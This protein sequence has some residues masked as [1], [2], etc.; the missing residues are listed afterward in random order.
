MKL[1]EIRKTVFEKLKTDKTNQSPR[2]DGDLIVMHNLSLTKADLI[3]KDFEVSYDKVKK[4]LSDT[5]KRLKK[6]PVAYILGK[7]EFMS[8][9]FFVNE[10][11]LIPRPDTEILVEHILDEYKNKAE[12][13][14]LVDIG[15]GSGCIAISLLKNQKNFTA[16]MLDISSGALSVA[17]KNAEKHG[18]IDRATFLEHNI[19]N[20]FL[21]QIQNV[22][23]IVSNPPYIPE[24]DINSL[25]PDVKDYEPLS[26]LSGGE[27]GLMF[28]ESIIK[29]ASLNMGGM[30]AF[31]VGINQSQ[32][33]AFLMRQNGFSDILTI[34]DYGGIDRVVSGRKL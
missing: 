25:M 8:L 3:T 20:G 33:V 24:K 11:T 15:T 14:H 10:H 17:K 28:Y 9:D 13:I 31:E 30:L 32:S 6:M 5:E 2:L 29:N 34:K 12:K 7:T 27:N 18:V 16:T 4:I 26:A 19:L 21:P 1:K 22:D 23:L